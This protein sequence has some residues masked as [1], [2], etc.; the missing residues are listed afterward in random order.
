MEYHQS[1]LSKHCRICG[2]R[3]QSS[4]KATVYD[5]DAFPDQLQMAFGFAVRGDSPL[6]HPKRFCKVA[7]GRL[8][9]AKTKG[10]PYKCSVKVYQWEEHEENCKVYN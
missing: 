4:N 7:M 2:G 10:V 5:V 9:E 6:V 1:E 3:L 8:I